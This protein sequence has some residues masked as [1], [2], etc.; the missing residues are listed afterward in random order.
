L[1][2][3]IEAAAT[4]LPDDDDHDDDDESLISNWSSGSSC[5]SLDEESILTFDTADSVLSVLAKGNTG[6]CCI[7]KGSKPFV[8]PNGELSW[9]MDPIECFSDYT[10]IVQAEENGE[11][12][13]YSVHRA[14]LAFGHFRCDY[15][16]KLFRSSFRENQDAESLF[17]FP[18]KITAFFPDFLD[19]LYNSKYSRNISAQSVEAVRFLSFYF[20]SYDLS[21]SITRIIKWKMQEI[22]DPFRAK[23]ALKNMSIYMKMLCEESE[24]NDTIELRACAVQKIVSHLTN[25]NL[26]SQ[27]DETDMLEIEVEFRKESRA[28][29]SAIFTSMSPDLLLSVLMQ[30]T[31]NL[32]NRYRIKDGNSTAP[33]CVEVLRYLRTNN[34]ITKWYFERMVLCLLDL[35]HVTAADGLR[36][37]ELLLE[38]AEHLNMATELVQSTAEFFRYGYMD[39]CPDIERIERILQIDYRYNNDE[40]STCFVFVER[41]IHCSSREHFVVNL[42]SRL[43]LVDLKKVIFIKTG[44]LPRL[45]ALS[46]SDD[47]NEMLTE[48][49]IATKSLEEI[50][51]QQ[52]QGHYREIYLHSRPLPLPCSPKSVTL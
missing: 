2:R 43:A 38:H 4:S 19:I 35:L 8:R 7:L 10:L 51:W 13:C 14:I 32:T 30:A 37:I 42:P 27:E 48:Q 1:I 46:K 9:R 50:P 45:Q 41:N 47:L 23:H 3:S 12:Q 22:G 24:I 6:R 36:F 44:L 16:A 20:C 31:A 40:C 11:R 33:F 21:S 39:A 52:F 34:G 29:L 5:R 18:S 26:S 49:D 15:F 28:A 17:I 25:F